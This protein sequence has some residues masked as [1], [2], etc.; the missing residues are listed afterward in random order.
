MIGGMTT[1]AHVTVHGALNGE[2]LVE[3]TLPDGRVLLAPD[4]SIASIHAET[5]TS[6]LGR[7]EF[8]DLFGDL[9]TDGEG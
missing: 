4:T 5:D 3:E 6:P 2:Y 8:D 1:P 9:P 7:E